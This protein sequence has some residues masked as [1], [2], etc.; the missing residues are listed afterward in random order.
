M[1]ELR[2]V[3]RVED[4]FR[5]EDLTEQPVYVVLWDNDNDSLS[6]RSIVWRFTGEELFHEGFY[7]FFSQCLTYGNRHFLGQG[8]S[9]RVVDFVTEVF[10]V[11]LGDFFDN[12]EQQL[13]RVEAFGAGGDSVDGIAAATHRR[14]VEPDVFQLI[15]G[16]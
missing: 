9:N 2:V 8:E 6:V 7:F 16:F 3:V 14:E 15:H 10:A 5:T 12:V 1:C 11:S 4:G 13:H